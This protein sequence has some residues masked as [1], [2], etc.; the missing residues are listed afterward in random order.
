MMPAIWLIGGTSE[1][2]RLVKELAEYPVRLYVSVAT[3]YGAGLI[4]SQPNLTVMAERMD[5]AAM[6]MFLEDK[7]PACVVDATHPYAT[8]VTATV[9]EACAAVGVEYHR[10][11]RPAGEAGDYVI[12]HDFA[13]AVELLNQLEG[14]IFLTTGSKNLFKEVRDSCPRILTYPLRAFTSAKRCGIIR[15]A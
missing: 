9:Q 7:R 14:N 6:K 4:E 2:R 15:G 10:L 1:G 5:I 12:V 11:V 13:E 8:V 3:E